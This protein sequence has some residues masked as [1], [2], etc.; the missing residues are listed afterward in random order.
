MSNRAILVLLSNLPTGILGID[1]FYAGQIGYGVAKLVTLGGF[2]IW[3]VIDGLIQ[4]IEGLF[5]KKSSSFG[6]DVLIDKTSVNAGFWTALIVL[7]LSIIHV[8][9]SVYEIERNNNVEKVTATTI[10]L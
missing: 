3:F 5:S 1:R 4:L 8:M 9:Y 7:I 2:G 10:D 6:N